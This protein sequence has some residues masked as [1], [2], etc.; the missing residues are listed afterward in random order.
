MVAKTPHFV[1]KN[2]LMFDIKG[3]LSAYS[4]TSFFRFF[5]WDEPTRRVVMPLSFYL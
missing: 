2:N 4:R 5:P 3:K 1:L